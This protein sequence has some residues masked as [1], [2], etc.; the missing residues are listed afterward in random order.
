MR[1]KFDRSERDM[2]ANKQ[3]EARTEEHRT[4][5]WKQKA[6]Q[7]GKGDVITEPQPQYPAV[8]L[9]NFFPNSLTLNLRL[10]DPLPTHIYSYIA[11]NDSLLLRRC[12]RT[13]H[14]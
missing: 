6:S 5:D 12:I 1:Y 7:N 10:W 8:S 2:G 13:K 3:A 11:G 14:I 4:S 9:A